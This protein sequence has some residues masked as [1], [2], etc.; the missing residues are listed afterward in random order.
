MRI[1]LLCR[2]PSVF[3]DLFP[4]S[5]E[6]GTSWPGIFDRR[7]FGTRTLWRGDET[8]VKR[9]SDIL[10]SLRLGRPTCNLSLISLDAVVQQISCCNGP[11]GARTVIQASTVCHP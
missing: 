10:V 11:A 3:S 9:G 4:S 1:L 6:I 2:L 8:L 5:T 7:R